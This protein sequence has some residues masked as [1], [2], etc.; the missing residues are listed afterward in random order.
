MD[1]MICE[2]QVWIKARQSIPYW[3][4]IWGRSQNQREFYTQKMD[5]FF[6]KRPM[7]HIANPNKSSCISLT[8]TNIR[9]GWSAYFAEF[10]SVFL[11]TTSKKPNVGPSARN[12]TILRKMLMFAWILCAFC[13]V[14]VLNC[15]VFDI[16]E[17]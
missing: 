1:V 4:G 5:Q 2:N 3:E 10:L 15:N 16:H 9:I 17:V 13:H 11:R 8:V 12:Y 7:S 6:N 14:F